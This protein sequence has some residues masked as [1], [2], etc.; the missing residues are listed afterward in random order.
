[1]VFA[2]SIS[3][4]KEAAR[5]CGWTR[6]LWRSNVGRLRCGALPRRCDGVR[7]MAPGTDYREGVSQRQRRGSWQNDQD[8]VFK[9]NVSL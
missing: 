6:A 3:R 2:R 8:S 4:W 7:R 9:N 1:M 5:G